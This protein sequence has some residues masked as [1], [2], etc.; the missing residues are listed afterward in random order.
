MTTLDNHETARE[1]FYDS[2]DLDYLDLLVLCKGQLLQK[3]K[4]G[5]DGLFGVVS[6]IL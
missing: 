5:I 1:D 4:I 6:A 3:D 2:Q